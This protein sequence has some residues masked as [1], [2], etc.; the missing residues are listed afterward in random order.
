M[1]KV[2]PV[3]LFVIL[4][5]LFAIN[6]SAEVTFEDDFTDSTKCVARSSNILFES[7]NPSLNSNRITKQ[8]NDD[9]YVIW[10]LDDLAYIEL[11]IAVFESS[12]PDMNT[13]I[14]LE[15][16]SDGV[17]WQQLEYT[18]G[19]PSGSGWVNYMITAELEQPSKY[20]KVI[21]TDTGDVSWSVALEK[22]RLYSINDI[23]D[24]SVGDESGT[25]TPITG[26]YSLIF[27]IIILAVSAISSIIVY[28]TISH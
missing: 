26:N 11:L 7:E 14:V 12:N 3:F 5:M 2:I 17:S 15:T 20:I 22:L 13:A 19:K 9:G 28:N 24:N 16:S 25:E 4:I 8:T 23:P 18:L 1:K 21:L 10:K 6:V 27:A